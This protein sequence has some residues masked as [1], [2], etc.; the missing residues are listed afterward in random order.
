MKRT[1]S[2]ARKPYIKFPYSYV[3]NIKSQYMQTP[4][5]RQ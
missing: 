5:W 3:N 2:A 1:H 4:A